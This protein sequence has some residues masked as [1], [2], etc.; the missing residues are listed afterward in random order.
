MSGE[1]YS[2]GMYP[3]TAGMGALFYVDQAGGFL[4]AARRSGTSVRLPDG[5]EV[6]SDRIQSVPAGSSVIVPRKALVGWEDPLL[7]ITSV[8]SVII[9]WKSLD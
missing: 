7:I 1:V 6:D 3:H 2:P 4:R 9:A 5:E 8:A